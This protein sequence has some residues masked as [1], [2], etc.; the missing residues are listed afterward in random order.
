M[1]LFRIVTVGLI[2]TLCACGRSGPLYLPDQ[3]LAQVDNSTQRTHNN[4]ISGTT[5]LS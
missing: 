1:I 4:D 2:L 5:E 3:P